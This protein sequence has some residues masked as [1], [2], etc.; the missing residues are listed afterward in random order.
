MSDG[1]GEKIRHDQTLDIPSAPAISPKEEPCQ[2]CIISPVESQPD[3]KRPPQQDESPI[4]SAAYVTSAQH[5]DDSHNATLYIGGLHPRV[6]QAHL[7]KLLKPFGVI[8]GLR[9]LEKR[10]IC[11]CQYSSRAEARSAQTALHGRTLF[12]RVLKVKPAIQS[13]DGASVIRREEASLDAR[14]EAL[15]RKLQQKDER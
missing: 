8:Q 3:G 9:Y 12:G 1:N 15:K 13:K 7:E 5:D 4:P 14:I 11:F 2:D 6:V 10:G